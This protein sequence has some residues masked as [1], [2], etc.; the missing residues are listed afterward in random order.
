MIR[1]IGKKGK[2]FRLKL[3]STPTVLSEHKHTKNKL[4]NAN[5]Q[6][7]QLKVQCD[8]YLDDMEKKNDNNDDEL[9]ALT[10]QDSIKNELLSSTLLINTEQYLSLVL[11]QPC[12]FCEEK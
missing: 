11:Q 8:H 2:R 1:T 6:I 12:D 3:Q 7:K 4:Y 10:I 9:L 5:Q